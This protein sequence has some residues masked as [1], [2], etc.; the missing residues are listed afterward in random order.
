MRRLLP[1]LGFLALCGS[2]RP[3]NAAAPQSLA[4]FFDDDAMV[5]VGE[6]L[7]HEIG[8]YFGLSEDEIERI[9]RDYWHRDA[10]GRT[11]E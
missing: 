1:M 10:P 3:A 4:P 6:T 11:P 2:L 5:V 9:E 7:I 8:H